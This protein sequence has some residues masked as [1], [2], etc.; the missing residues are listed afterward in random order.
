M[1]CKQGSE[2]LVDSSCDQL[3]ATSIANVPSHLTGCKRC[4]AEFVGQQQLA[5][6]LANL[7][8]RLHC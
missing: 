6:M 5:N 8:V 1:N 4:T 2:L 3:P 7:Q